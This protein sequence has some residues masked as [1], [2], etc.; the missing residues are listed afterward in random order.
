VEGTDIGALYQPAASEQTVGGDWYDAFPVGDHQLALVIADVAGHGREAAALMVQVR[1]IFRA[2]AVEHRTPATVL[3]RVNDVVLRLRPSGL[4]V[5]CC[6]AVLDTE[7][8]D[9]SWGVAGHP[10]PVLVA[11]GTPALGE[12]P[13]GPPLAVFSTARYHDSSVT[14][15]RGDRVYLYTD[16]LVERRGEPIDVGLERLCASV[17]RLGATRPQRAVEALGAQVDDQFDDLAVLCVER[18]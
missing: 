1:N 10:P 14:L 5:T 4:F 6:Y 8:G 15:D 2:V 17:G 11:G 16:G 13:A 3:S 18:R 7:R 12:A 9:L